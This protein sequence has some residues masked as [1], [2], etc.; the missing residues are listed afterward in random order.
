MRRA[1]FISGLAV[2][3]SSTLLADFS[4]EQTSTVTGGMVA[5]M[6][7]FA[8]A[9]SKKAREPIHG[10][11]A[12]K[13]NKML[14]RDAGAATIIDLDA[15][16][17]THMDFQKKTYSVMTFEQMKQMLDQMSQKMKQSKAQ[18]QF[19]VS[20]KATGATRQIS[21]LDA[22]EML[23]TMEMQ[24]TDQQSGQ[25][26]AM[27]I[28]NDMWLA[29]AIPGYGEVR[30]FYKR[31]AA[32]INWTPGG[33]FMMNPQVSQG[34]A[35]VYKQAAELDGMPVLQIITMGAAGQPAATA[36]NNQQAPAQQPAPDPQQDKPSVA[37]AVGGAL[38]GH[39]G[40]GH[41]KKQNQQD[42]D[43][44]QPATSDNSSGTLLEMNTETTNFSSSPVDASEFAIPAGF[45]QIEPDTRGRAQ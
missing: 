10:T 16:T 37:D 19:K 38:A 20:A 28:T 15:E 3:A 30:D 32:K 34:M 8:G 42:Q 4:Y 21:G 27:V 11:V 14:H 29:P 2:L 1:V 36:S 31:M 24:G 41:K 39:F 5:R 44:Q 9:F 25:Q 23:V 35:E 40:F 33:T 6:M 13:G 45:R 7:K 17:I 18:M 22:K 12:I 26:G 43:Q